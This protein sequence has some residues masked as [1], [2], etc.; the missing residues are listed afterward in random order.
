MS[1]TFQRPPSW[2][3]APRTIPSE[4]YIAS[5]ASTGDK[6]EQVLFK[7]QCTGI[8]GPGILELL[9]IATHFQRSREKEV[10][11]YPFTLSYIITLSSE[12]DS[13]PSYG[14]SFKHLR[15]LPHLRSNRKPSSVLCINRH[16]NQDPQ[17]VAGRP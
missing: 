15:S 12:Q 10:S 1:F 16:Y 11:D 8:Q 7:V 17:I 6:W 5:T 2:R 9:G 13:W 3:N 4:T 14:H